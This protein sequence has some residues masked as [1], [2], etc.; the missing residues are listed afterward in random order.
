MKKY[1]LGLLLFCI[2]VYTEAS[3]I[4]MAD[5]TIFYEDGYYYLTGTFRSGSGFNM[6]RSTDLVHWQA[7]GNATNNLAMWREDTFGDANFWAPQIFKHNGKYYLAYAANEQIGIAES[8]NPMGPYKQSRIH[9]ITHTTGQI[10]PFL[11][12]D[13]DGKVYLYY[14]RFVGGNTLYVARM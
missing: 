5:P 3:V 10:D 12:H 6:Y 11:F 7:V 9:E 8:S 2:S 4:T 1:F 14:V 13:D